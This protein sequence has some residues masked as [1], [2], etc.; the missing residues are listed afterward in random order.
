LLLLL[1]AAAAPDYCAPRPTRSGPVPDRP[2][3]L[4]NSTLAGRRHVQQG[5]GRGVDAGRGRQ[6]GH[7]PGA[8]AASLS[9]FGDDSDALGCTLCRMCATR[10]A[11]RALLAM[12][13]LWYKKPP[14]GSDPY[15][16][17]HLLDFDAA[18]NS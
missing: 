2:S 3:A 15:H 17:N 18:L 11:R 4:D 10:L 8:Q 9:V 16:Q 5:W 14:A 12:A 7:G 1:A 6:R 13:L